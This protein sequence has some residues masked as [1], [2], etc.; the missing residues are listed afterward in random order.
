[1][2]APLFLDGDD[3]LYLVQ[4]LLQDGNTLWAASSLADVVQTEKAP[5]APSLVVWELGSLIEI[6]GF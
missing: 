4:C 5:Q 2:S 6:V 1:M 3:L